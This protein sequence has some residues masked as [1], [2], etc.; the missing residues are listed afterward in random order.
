MS[1][2][3]WKQSDCVTC[4]VR[5]LVR[6]FPD[7]S[8]EA[9]HDDPQCEV[10]LELLKKKADTFTAIVDPKWTQV[11]HRGASVRGGRA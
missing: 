8:I 3:D 1:G 10:W 2:G 4:G 11:L 6:E 9:L 5:L 7:G